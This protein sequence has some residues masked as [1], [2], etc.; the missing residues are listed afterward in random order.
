MSPTPYLDARVAFTLGEDYAFFGLPVPTGADQAMLQGHNTGLARFPRRQP[1]DRFVKKWLQIRVGAWKR[2]RV[3]ESTVTP[4]YLKL[5]DNEF[6]PVSRVTLTHATGLD[7]DWSIDRLNNDGAYAP[8]NLLVMSSRVNHIK[9]TLTWDEINRY[10][11]AGS[12]FGV[13]KALPPGK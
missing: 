7:T 5:I 13:E 4:D 3:F 2:N 6:C 11:E 10:A 9:G 8:G 1:A 12:P